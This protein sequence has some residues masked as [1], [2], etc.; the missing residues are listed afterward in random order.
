MKKHFIPV[1]LI[2]LSIGFLATTN[3]QHPEYSWSNLF[4]DPENPQSGNAVLETTDGGYIIAGTKNI[5]DS[6]DHNDVYILRLDSEGNELWTK[7]YGGEYSVQGSS[8]CQANDGG[9]L[10]AGSIKLVSGAKADAWVLKISA[11]GDSLWSSSFGGTS[12]DQAYCIRPTSDNGFIVTGYN[13]VPAAGLGDQVL[14]T[15][16]DSLG[17]YV[18]DETYGDQYQNHGY[19]VEET[20]DGGYIIA[21]RTYRSYTGNSDWLVIKTS[22]E[23]DSLW[24]YIYGLEKDDEAWRVIE[25]TADDNYLVVG[26]L[27]V[28]VEM[29]DKDYYYFPFGVDCLDKDGNLIWQEIYGLYKPHNAYD[30]SLTHDGNLMVGGT[31]FDPDW[32]HSDIFL[33]EIDAGSGDSLWMDTF[34]DY[35]NENAST[36]LQTSDFGYIISGKAG[37]P[38]ANKLVYV[39]RLDYSNATTSLIQRNVGIGLELNASESEDQLSMICEQNKV[40]G[41]TVTLDT[42]WHPSVGDL[43]IILEHTGT[44]A[45]LANQPTNSGADFLGTIFFDGATRP[46]S[47]GSAPYTG[48]FKPVEPLSVFNEMDP[49]GDW[50]LRIIDHAVGGTK[51]SAEKML[52]SWGIKLLVDK[53]EGTFIGSPEARD[54]FILKP[55]YPNPFNDQTSID[56]ELTEP[57]F[58]RLSIYDAG[59]RLVE[60]LINRDYSS[61][62]HRLIW[63]AEKQTP[64][65]YFIRLEAGKHLEYRKIILVR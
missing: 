40:Y 47:S 23:G 10:I 18:W 3:A 13:S 64:G 12:A 35:V 52:D 43:E 44:S 65:S 5:I 51:K 11:D 8:I 30:A 57:S 38:P 20:S 2:I 45:I 33:Y 31:S 26:N 25:N 9:F 41:V 53:A 42:L 17:N 61:G 37:N 28:V 27:T 49:N 4:G 7:T 55:N 32:T 63:K 36:F 19:W 54:N 16:L 60:E 56:F 46:V 15:K 6:L 14:L 59:G 50:T 21:G 22:S 34:G 58:V 1:C 48:F 62:E 29:T 39:M 24:S